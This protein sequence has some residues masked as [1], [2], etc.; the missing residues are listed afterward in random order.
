MAG[1][2]AE[3][4]G[5][6]NGLASWR[7]ITDCGTTCFSFFSENMSGSAGSGSGSGSSPACAIIRRLSSRAASETSAFSSSRW[8]SDGSRAAVWARIVPIPSSRLSWASRCPSVSSESPLTRARS[9]RASSAA[10]WNFVRWPPV[11]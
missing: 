3:K 1:A 9:S 10:T 6:R 7:W 5:V 2:A 8:N 11:I 4:S